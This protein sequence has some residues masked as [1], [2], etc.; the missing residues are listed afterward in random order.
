MKQII[1]TGIA[2]FFAPVIYIGKGIAAAGRGI[3]TVGTVVE[4]G[5]L[6]TQAFGAENKERWHAKAAGAAVAVA[7]AA[8]TLEAVR[9]TVLETVGELLQ[10]GKA[11]VVESPFGGQTA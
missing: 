3:Q 9:A 2:G 10:V 6:R 5:G 4:V 11:S 8:V 7:P 1:Y